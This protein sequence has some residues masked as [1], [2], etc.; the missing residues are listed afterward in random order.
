MITTWIFY[1]LLY[2]YVL[3]LSSKIGEVKGNDNKTCI[4][5]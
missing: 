2:S 3:L 5:S 4:S 1:F